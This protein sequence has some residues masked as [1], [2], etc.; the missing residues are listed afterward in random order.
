MSKELMRQQWNEMAVK[1]P[2]FGITS[3]PEF[4]KIDSIDLNRFWEIGRIHTDNLMAKVGLHNTRHLR[5]IEIG[6]GIGR[7]THRFSELFKEVYAM[8][9]SS[10]MLEKA[11]QYWAHLKNVHFI[12]G[13]G[14]DLKP[15]TDQ[16]VEFVFS[17]YVLNHVIR[18][19]IVLT[20]IRETSRVLRPSG[21]ALLHFR[22]KPSASLWRSS[23]LGRWLKKRKE[24]GMQQKG[25]WWNKGIEKASLDYQTT[26]VTEF[27]KKESWSGCEVPWSDVKSVTK[28]IGLKII[29]D[30]IVEA[31]QTHFVFLILHKK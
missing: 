19:E 10:E 1:N 4:E 28:E 21:V 13:S 22:I 20:Y 16:S 7:M 29:K 8:D 18:P 9:I 6:C 11:R 23:S 15:M 24:K 5:M 27:G 30:E 12:E 17:F 3:W 26:L 31:A 25:F 14:E 2:F